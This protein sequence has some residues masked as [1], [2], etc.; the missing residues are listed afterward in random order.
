MTIF[1]EAVSFSV[2]EV[3]RFHT[4]SLEWRYHFALFGIVFQ[5]FCVDNRDTLSLT[6]S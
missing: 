1:Y 2:Y 4:K 6:T 5:R 3:A